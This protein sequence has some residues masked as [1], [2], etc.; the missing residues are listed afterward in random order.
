MDLSKLEKASE[1]DNKKPKNTFLSLI[2]EGWEEVGGRFI[3]MKGMNGETQ[4]SRVFVSESHKPIENVKL[5]STWQ[6]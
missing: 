5:S 2:E 1:I 6:R 3:D 4:D